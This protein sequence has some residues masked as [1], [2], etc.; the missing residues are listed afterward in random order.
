V[1]IRD[2]LEHIT[3]DA[4]FGGGLTFFQ[5]APG[6]G[7]RANVDA[8]LLASFAARTGRIPRLAVDLGAGAGAVGLSL[9]FRER[10]ARVAFV[11]RDPE[12]VRICQ[13]N[14]EANHFVAR[15]SIHRGDLARKLEDIAPK[16]L[17]TADLVVTNPP[18]NAVHRDARSRTVTRSS[19]RRAAR[20]GE[21]L[22]FLR[23][24]S[25]ALGRRGRVCLCYPAHALLEAVFLARELGLEPKRVRFVHGRGDRP[26][27]IALIELS[28]GKAGGLVI[29]PALVETEGG[30]PTAELDSL[31]LPRG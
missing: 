5:P 9:L 27:R 29:E 17:H 15:A 7:Y 31:L 30:R 8:I 6:H 25:E 14:V 13:R 18:Y 26:A 21:L 11:E 28:R 20:H 4:L 24:S 22:P 2:R 3:E 10:A 12:L 19:S 16:L 23:A 1:P